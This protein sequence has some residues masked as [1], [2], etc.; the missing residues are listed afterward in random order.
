M[1][2]QK[3]GE[4]FLKAEFKKD[5]EE[6][7][8]I[9][10]Q[11]IDPLTLYVGNLSQE[12]TKESMVNIF[13]KSRRIDIGFA[14]KM[15]FTRYA[16]VT[17]RNVEDSIETFKRTRSTQLHSKSLI[18]RFR[19]LH[20]TV[21]MPGE[22]KPQ[23]PAKKTNEIETNTNQK[24]PDDSVTEIDA[25]SKTEEVVIDVSNIKEEPLDEE[26]DVKPLINAKSCFLPGNIED[27]CSN[28]LPIMKI[29]EEKDE[30]SYKE[31]S[32][33]TSVTSSTFFGSP[34]CKSE[35]SGKLIEH[36]FYLY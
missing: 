11:D 22:S 3:F 6:D 16:F 19:R 5:R 33:S 21:G 18:V 35:Y 31:E 12:I 34:N 4:G 1:N 7:Q 10:P 30:E 2:A 24:A 9:G 13:P 32:L 36:Q 17:F 8:N 15:K 25:L 29:K 27:Y 28:H 20:G 23:N 26:A 14:K